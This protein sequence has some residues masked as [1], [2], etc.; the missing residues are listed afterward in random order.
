LFAPSVTRTVTWRVAPPS[1][2]GN[3][4]VVGWLLPGAGGWSQ[5]QVTVNGVP[6]QGEVTALDGL[7]FVTVRAGDVVRVTATYGDGVV[8]DRT[9]APDDAEPVS[10]PMKADLFPPGGDE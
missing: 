9:L 2:D 1:G 4:H 10:G 8:L 5:P 6:R 7:G 3:W